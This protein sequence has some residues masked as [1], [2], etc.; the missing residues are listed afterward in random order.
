M[1]SVLEN[2][3][4]K[5]PPMPAAVPVATAQ[6]D[7]EL[8]SLFLDETESK[9]KGADIIDTAVYPDF[10]APDPDDY[11]EPDISEPGNPRPDE[12]ATS[13]PQ[14]ILMSLVDLPVDTIV[15]TVDIT[16]T[17]LIVRGCKLEDAD[18]KEA[19]KLI[20]SE[21]DKAALAKATSRYLASQHI[22]VTPLTGLII[23][24]A[25]VYGKK[26]MYG[27]RLKKLIKQNNALLDEIERLQAE[28]DD[29]QQRLDE[30]ERE[31]ED[32]DKEETDSETE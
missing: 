19:D 22:K 17:E 11:P 9:E 12:A 7:D 4:D 25:L 13:E 3:V 23:T 15:D 31:Q 26:L 6:T 21:A 8:I 20:T 27:L 29:M 30:L 18:D 10:E 32:E 28:K 14:K 1:S 16:L 2:L 5:Q 24:A